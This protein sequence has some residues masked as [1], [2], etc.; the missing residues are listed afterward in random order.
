MN[1]ILVA[2]LFTLSSFALGCATSVTDS[3]S[4]VDPD[5]TAPALVAAPIEL[6]APVVV[7]EPACSD[8]DALACA[9]RG[10]ACGSRPEDS[11]CYAF[12]ACYEDVQSDPAAVDA[13]V[14]ANPEG[15]AAWAELVQC[16]CACELFNE[17]FCN[18]APFG[19]PNG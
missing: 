10:D 14:E 5:E 2:V 9:A 6:P 12:K 16:G 15:A 7:V 19:H 8:A 4:E 3:S 17:T 11:A 18:G 13:C 1:R